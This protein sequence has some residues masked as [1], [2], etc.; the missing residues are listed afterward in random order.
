MSNPVRA[1]TVLLVA[2]VVAVVSFV[3]AGAAQAS[4][5]TY[6]AATPTA[7][8]AAL[9]VAR[10]G[11]TIL[12]D[13]SYSGPV[14]VKSRSYGGSPLTV[15]LN[16][17]TV[18]GVQVWTS[19]N[20]RLTGG[21][22]VTPNSASGTRCFDVR[23]STEIHIDN[24]GGSVCHNAVVFDRVFGFSL[25]NSSFSEYRA[26]GVDTV[27]SRDGLIA[28]N[29]FAEPKPIP[30]VY[31]RATGKLV[32]DGDHADCWQAWTATDRA[33]KPGPFNA[34]ITVRSNTCTGDTQGFSVFNASPGH[35]G[36]IVIEDNAVLIRQPNAISLHN[37]CA[38]GQTCKPSVIRNNT[39]AALRPM[40]PDARGVPFRAVQINV[41]P[42]ATPPLVCGNVG[43]TK[44]QGGKCP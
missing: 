28:F 8:G 34:N 1:L 38:T 36:G 42:G 43:G 26:D 37:P 27:S 32:R 33:G 19:H 17:A 40:A 4:P 35:G 20:V 3:A 30:P 44:A 31:D 29:I 39:I 12:L 14:A 11:D 15:D 25:T 21:E 41:K 10:P 6:P 5:T 2:L 24:V 13:P 23:N 22:S 7:F 18:A 9:K 16:G